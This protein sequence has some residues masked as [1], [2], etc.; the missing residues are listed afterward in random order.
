MCI[1]KCLLQTLENTH[2]TCNYVNPL[3]LFIQLFTLVFTRAFICLIRDWRWCPES[4]RLSPQALWTDNG[5][6][7]TL[8]TH[9]RFVL[10]IDPLR[11]PNGIWKE[12][13]LKRLA[14]PSTQCTILHTCHNRRSPLTSYSDILH[15]NALVLLMLSFV[16]HRL[17]K[18]LSATARVEECVNG[19]TGSQPLHKPWCA[20]KED[21]KNCWKKATR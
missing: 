12:T 19:R 13:C 16:L 4:S 17:H 9:F 11:A 20:W 1:C 3:W 10:Q 15:M 2:S 6:R 18:K 5:Q 8:Y 7:H 21:E 14:R